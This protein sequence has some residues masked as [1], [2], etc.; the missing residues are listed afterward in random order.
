MVGRKQTGVPVPLLA[1]AG[2][3]GAGH[4]AAPAV[5]GAPDEGVPGQR[6]PAPAGALLGWLWQNRHHLRHRPCLDTTQDGG[7][8]FALI[9]RG[10]EF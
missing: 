5:H 2:P 4:G 8:S 1:V 9:R 6:D 10:R 3:R 7:E